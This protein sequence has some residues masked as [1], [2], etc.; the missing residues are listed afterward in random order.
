[1]QQK[2]VGILALV[3]MFIAGILGRDIVGN[4]LVDISGYYHYLGL[5]NLVFIVLLLIARPNM[6]LAMNRKV[7]AI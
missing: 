1:M 7:E 2:V 5:V 6:L 4:Y 3:L